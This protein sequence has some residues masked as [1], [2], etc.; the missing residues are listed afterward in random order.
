MRIAVTGGKGGTGKSTVAINIAWELSKRYRVVL[1]DA[2]V[3]CPNDHI[4]LSTN[5]ENS[6]EEYIFRPRFNYKKCIRCSLCVKNCSESAIVMFK[7]GYPFLMPQL[8][9][10]CRT[11]QLVCPV[12]AIEEDK[13]H[14]GNT[15]VSRV[16]DNLTLVTGV[17]KEGE[18]RSYPLVL[19]TRKRG[20]ELPHDIIIYDTS[21]GTGNHVAAAI[22]NADI[23]VVV[24]EPT[25]LGIHDLKMIFRLLEKQGKN[26]YAVI[27]RYNIVQD[28]PDLDGISVLEKIPLSDRIVESYIK[29]VPVAKLYP[30]SEESMIFSNIAK[31]VV[32]LLWQR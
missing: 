19:S 18:E 21:A 23:A 25:P 2:D 27:N 15:Y 1:V 22:E 8:C 16:K 30:E 12:D 26:G 13:K 9:S 11:C 17:L 32:D 6:M 24:T 20:E 7:E 31:R 10:G 5:L 4:L 3:E 14:I 29:G 28:L